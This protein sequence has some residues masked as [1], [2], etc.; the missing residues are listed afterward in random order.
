M[1]CAQKLL[2]GKL[3]TSRV[4]CLRVRF[5]LP[6]EHSCAM[7]AGVDKTSKHT[8]GVDLKDMEVR[9]CERRH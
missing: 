1:M 5:R 8:G 6:I 3:T 9:N 7:N 4:R 2:V